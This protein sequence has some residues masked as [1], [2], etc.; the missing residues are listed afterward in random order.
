MNI[1]Q[2]NDFS[3]KVQSSIHCNFF[4]NRVYFFVLKENAKYSSRQVYERQKTVLSHFDDYSSSCSVLCHVIKSSS[5][6]ISPKSTSWK[7]TEES[8]RKEASSKSV[9]EVSM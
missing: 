7:P 6:I 8:E 2:D 9:R 3:S 1:E 4:F 5:V